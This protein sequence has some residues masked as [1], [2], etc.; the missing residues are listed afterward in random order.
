MGGLIVIKIICFISKKTNVVY[1]SKWVYNQSVVGFGWLGFDN[2]PS[3]LRSKMLG[4]TL[5][6]PNLSSKEIP[7]RE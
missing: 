5:T 1:M 4:I 7:F 3:M 2:K 6:L